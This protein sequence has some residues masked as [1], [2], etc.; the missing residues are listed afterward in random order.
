M[1]FQNEIFGGIKS[2]KYANEKT[3]D[4]KISFN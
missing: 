2:I 1:V 3:L 4:K